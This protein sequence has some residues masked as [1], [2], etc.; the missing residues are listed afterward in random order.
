MKWTSS[1][2]GLA[3]LFTLGKPSFL[4][5]ASYK[6]A[7]MQLVAAQADSTP[8]EDAETGITFQSFTNEVDV[9][10][11]LALPADASAEKPYDVIL[12]VISPITNG[13][14]A[15]AWGG[16]MTYNPLTVVW[17][18]G[19]DAQYSSR[20]ALGYYTPAMYEDA[21]YTVLKGT[22]SNATHF[23]LTA[24]CTGCASWPDFDGNV[25]T[26]D[27]ASQVNFAYAYSTTPV[28]E[29]ANQES[30]FSIHDSVGHWT[31]DLAAARSDKFSSWVAANKVN[32]TTY[33]R[34]VRIGRFEY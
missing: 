34:P 1:L 32:T 16:S 26:L 11:R 21:T 12:Q 13:W 30:T 19:N 23:K 18:N 20:Q 3:S 6:R 22:G 24:L 4:N 15:W 10:Y 2:A 33:R 25:M 5:S 31:H 8:V 9:T 29:P 17:A 27:G 14:V 7:Q 28:D